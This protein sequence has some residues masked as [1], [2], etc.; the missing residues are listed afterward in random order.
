MAML[1]GMLIGGTPEY[2]AIRLFHQYL[3][4]IH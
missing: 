3:A 1:I 2:V 4:R